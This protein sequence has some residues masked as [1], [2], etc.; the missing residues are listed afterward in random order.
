M[1][2]FLSTR[3]ADYTTLAK[4]SSM[5]R[6]DVI[7]RIKTLIIK[8]MSVGPNRAAYL[9]ELIWKEAVD[10]ALEEVKDEYIRLAKCSNNQH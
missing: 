1:R 7:E 10:P 3:L 4:L 6:E 5:T 9:A 2:T 8:Q